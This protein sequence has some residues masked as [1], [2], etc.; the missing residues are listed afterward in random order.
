VVVLTEVEH[1]LPLSEKVEMN[2]GE[3]VKLDDVIVIDV[4]DLIIIRQVLHQMLT[5]LS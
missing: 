1:T 2:G 4:I 5:N 3:K